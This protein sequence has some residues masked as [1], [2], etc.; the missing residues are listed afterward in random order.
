MLR[1]NLVDLLA[2]KFVRTTSKYGVN[3]SG[4]ALDSS[5]KM[6]PFLSSP[7]LFGAR[8]TN[9]VWVRKI[10]SPCIDS[11]LHPYGN[12]APT[13]FAFSQKIAPIIVSIDK[14]RWGIFSVFITAHNLNIN[15][16]IPFFDMEHVDLRV[17]HIDGMQKMFCGVDSV[18]FLRS[19]IRSSL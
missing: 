13:V 10:R 11:R 8:F 2:T 15:G 17:W 14:S 7:R 6:V 1:I 12:D 16:D 3:F 18:S 4:V 5:R 19:A 9:V